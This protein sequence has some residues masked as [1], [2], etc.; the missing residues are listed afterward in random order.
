MTQS[1][2][3]IAFKNEVGQTLGMPKTL[4]AFRNTVQH[5][6]NNLGFSHFDITHIGGG[7]GLEVVTS[8]V[9]A[10]LLDTYFEQDFSTNDIINDFLC[11][12]LTP[13][14]FYNLYQFILRSPAHIEQMERSSMIY[15]LMCNYRFYDSYSCPAH[16]QKSEKKL[17][18]SVH[19]EGV[20]PDQ[21]KKLVSDRE[22]K[23]IALSRLIYARLNVSCFLLS[24][25]TENIAKLNKGEIAILEAMGKHSMTQQQAADF[26]GLAESTV[27]TYCKHIKEKLGK[28]TISGAIYEALRLGIIAIE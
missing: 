13:Q 21:F 15:E 25:T 8:N 18:F 22:A 28:R 7:D 27:K 5:I 23:I 4:R 14:Y 9:P 16:D 11:C 6:V 17:V 26:A 12:A 24:D 1:K 19:A 2:E 20:K 10:A 3:L